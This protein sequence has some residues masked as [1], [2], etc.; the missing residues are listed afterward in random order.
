MQVQPTLPPIINISFCFK[1]FF[2]DLQSLNLTFWLFSHS[3]FCFLHQPASGTHYNSCLN[4]SLTSQPQKFPFGPLSS[5]WTLPS[6]PTDSLQISHVALHSQ[7]HP[8]GSSYNSPWQNGAGFLPQ[9]S[10][11]ALTSR[12]P[13]PLFSP[14]SLSHISPFLLAFLQLHI[15]SASHQVLTS[16][17]SSHFSSRL[18]HL[19]HHLAF[20]PSTFS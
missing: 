15:S 17:P 11:M 4:F 18:L 8:T 1:K 5:Q 20:A 13:S 12:C 14:T 2:S 6:H 3:P 16:F 19:L 10:N 7:S 9:I